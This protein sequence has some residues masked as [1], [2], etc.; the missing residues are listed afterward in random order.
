MKAVFRVDASVAVG[1]GHVIR[2]LVLAEALARS[3]WDCA[4]ACR[5]GTKAM[6]FALADC[7]HEVREFSEEV[8]DEPSRFQTIWP[9]GCELLVIDHYGLGAPYESACRPWAGKIL[10]IDDLADRPH[11]ADI[12]LDQTLG[13]T[14]ADY[15]GLV[16][17]HCQ[18]LA[19]AAYALIRPRFAELRHSTL[20]RRDSAGSV[21]RV[22]VSMGMSDPDNVT[23]TVLQG[24]GDSGL[25]AKVDV[26][27]GAAAPHLDAVR[28]QAE[29]MT[30]QVQVHVDVT[31]MADL[32]ARADIAIGAAG[33]T[34]WER[35]CLGLPSLIVITADNQGKI[36]EELERK[37]AVRV[38][39]RHHEITADTIGAALTATAS[40]NPMRRRWSVN[41][42][43]LCDGRGTERVMN[44]LLR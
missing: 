38:L 43:G 29:T 24:I 36:A 10:V 23:G 9:D 16:P 32:M 31:D 28:R 19:G 34:S 15:A 44:E 11:D 22:L 14:P 21:D 26:V 42:S 35:C 7:T 40:D 37:G 17:P 2:C 27:L 8:V 41:A 30:P 13:R 3:G 5:E 18:F 6:V 25:D 39:G 33:S 20:R 4:F 1:A 12:L